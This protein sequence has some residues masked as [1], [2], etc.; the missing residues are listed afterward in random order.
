[1]AEEKET[2]T[3]RRGANK[4]K[5][6]YQLPDGTPVPYK[7]NNPKKFFRDIIQHCRGTKHFENAEIVV[8]PDANKPLGSR[9]IIP[10]PRSPICA[11]CGLDQQGA[12]MP[13]MDYV[14]SDDPIATILVDSVSRKE[15]DRGSVGSSGTSSWIASIILK[16]QDEHGVSLRDIRWVPLTRCAGRGAKIPNYKTHGNW[17]RYHAIKDLMDHPPRV[18]IP[19]GTAALGLLSHKSNAQDWSGRLLTWRGWPDDWLTNREFMLERPDLLDPSKTV[20]GH[21]LFGPAPGVR[22]PMVP[23]QA[24]RLVFLNQN[25]RLIDK[26]FDELSYALSIGNKEVPPLEYIRPWY[27]ISM[28]PDEI[29]QV[30][31]QVIDHGK[32]H[33]GFVLAFDT[34]TTSLKQWAYF[35]RFRIDD[36]QVSPDPHIV[37]LMF[38]WKNPETG[39][40]E[41]I[42][43]PWEYPES[44]LLEHLEK[45]SPYV[46]EALSSSNVVGH[47]LTFD[48]LF[49]IAT[50]GRKGTVGEDDSEYNP[51]LKSGEWNPNWLALQERINKLCEHAKHDTW[52][53]AFVS[54]QRRGSLGLE[55]LAYDYVPELAGYEEEMTLLI[56]LYGDEMNPANEKGGHYAM[57]PKELWDTHLKP[58]VMGDVEVTYG[59]YEALSN[60]LDNS[61]IYKIPLAAP[62]RPGQFRYYTPPG[63]AWVYE[64]VV[65]PASQTLTKMMARG[66]YVNKNELEAQEAHYPKRVA[67][68]KKNLRDVDP[69]IERWCVQKVQEASE[70]S[71]TKDKTSEERT[72]NDSAWEFDLENKGQLRELLFDLMRCKIQRLTKNGRE[73][74]GED[75]EGW[76]DVPY[77]VLKQYAAV[78]R[79]TLNKLA[80]D[81]PNLR[82]LQEYRKV[83]KLYSTYIRPM[84]NMLADKLDKKHRKKEPHLSVDHCLHASF[85]LTG[86]RGG[87]LS[88]RDPNLQ[89]LPNEGLVK[90]LFSSRFGKEGCIYAADLSQ[91]ELRLMA[92]ACGDESMVNAYLNDIDIHSLTASKIVWQDGKSIPYEHFTKKH[93]EA[94]QHAGQS[95]EAK[96]LELRRKIAKTVNF[97]TGYGGGAFGLQNVLANNE[98]YM[99]IEDCENIIA[100]FFDA[101]PALKRFLGVYKTF[102]EDHAV[103]VSMFGRV[104]HFEEIYSDDNEARSRALRAGCNHLIQ[105]TAS[106]MMLICLVTIET[107][108][109][110]ANLKSLLVSTVHDSLVIDAVRRE[111][112]EVHNIVF[113]V[114]N[115]IPTVIESLMPDYDTSWMIVPFAG[116]SE[117]GLNYLETNK[118]S[119][120]NPDWD[121]LLMEKKKKMP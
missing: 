76:K 43:F 40:P 48:E 114:M 101:Y 81:H 62:N 97:L 79:Y 64:N 80:V 103:A 88:C 14:G 102:I 15:D 118:I 83:Y 74:Y 26:W 59:A 66:M 47:N 82:P 19:V 23:L 46:I 73:I 7:G 35:R 33:P 107:L 24:P 110:Q 111:L 34:E 18:V 44:E 69:V 52:H 65:S 105:A 94:L 61:R 63:R 6:T 13:Y 112:D 42:G 53:M 109:R 25:Q 68:L 87:R 67:E 98:V 84:R 45:I 113:S 38:R 10:G 106:D 92:A 36:I 78:D 117:V 70:K 75:E 37:F 11:K 90:R 16:L 9:P 72:G 99:P 31:K 57:C 28:D 89:Q 3:K 5:V 108:M 4:G 1:M 56:D 39:E 71:S 93:M 55:I 116:D 100:S 2:P 22:I 29:I 86:T 32:K 119:G 12:K 21:P 95:E 49:T 54:L 96:K 91:I 115:N 85:L 51:I 50:I 77:D 58:Y 20:K 41:S 121:E 60:K 8:V 120:D 27:R 30:L 104:R 17:C